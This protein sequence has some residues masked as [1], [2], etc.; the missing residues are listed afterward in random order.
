[1]LLS[2]PKLW[3]I[4]SMMSKV[5]CREHQTLD[6]DHIDYLLVGGDDTLVIMENLR[7]Y[8]SI[9]HSYVS[10]EAPPQ[11]IYMGHFF[12]Q[13]LRSSYLNLTQE[14]ENIT[15]ASGGGYIINRPILDSIL[16]CSEQS[17]KALHAED[18]MTGK[19]LWEQQTIPLWV[20]GWPLPD[21]LAKQHTTDSSIPGLA[22]QHAKDNSIQVPVAFEPLSPRPRAEKVLHHNGEH[23]RGPVQPESFMFHSVFGA[24]RLGLHAA[25]YGSRDGRHRQCV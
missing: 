11:P 17:I 14:Y 22:K 2:W 7:H 5:W 19:C 20:E 23:V 21:G 9:L 25:I 8:L 13:V 4:W 6:C 18:L 1:M 15:Y 10:R 16:R 3:Q 12:S 24:Q